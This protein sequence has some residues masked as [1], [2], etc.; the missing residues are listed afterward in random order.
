MPAQVRLLT[1]SISTPL[2]VPRSL[3][4]ESQ[5]EQIKGLKSILAERGL[6]GKST[7]QQIAEVKAAR[8]REIDE[9]GIDSSEF[10]V[11]T[12]LEDRRAGRQE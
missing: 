7:K 12:L 5:E 2:R 9:E 3:Q 1:N 8:E 6:S 4:K 10:W 11:P